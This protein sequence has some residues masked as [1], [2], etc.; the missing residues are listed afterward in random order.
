MLISRT[1]HCFKDGKAYLIHKHSKIE[2]DFM[3]YASSE[4][5]GMFGFCV[6]VF[7]TLK[8]HSF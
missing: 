4:D 2:N 5:T 3:T 1:N 8:C 6:N 7:I